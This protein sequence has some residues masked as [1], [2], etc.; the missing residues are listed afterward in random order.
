MVQV[1]ANEIVKNVFP[2]EADSPL[3]QYVLP[4]GVT[5]EGVG[6]QLLPAWA[7]QARNA[8]GGTQDY[9]NQYSVFLAQETARFRNGERKTAPTPRELSNRTRNWF[10]LGAAMKNASPVSITPTPAS[11]FYIERARAYR[12][13][14]FAD[15]KAYADQHSGNDW[16]AQYLADFPEYFEMSMTLTSNTT[17]IQATEQG[18]DALKKHADE[19]AKNP[20]YGWA[21]AGPENTGEFDA[22]VYTWMKTHGTS[23][24]SNK[25]FLEKLSPEEALAKVQ[26]ERGWI[27][28]TK[29]ARW[30]DTQMEAMGLRNL[31][32][33]GAADLAA[34]KSAFVTQLAKE[35]P[36]WYAEYTKR[37]SG[38]VDNFI[39]VMTKAWE[40]S[41]E[42]K[43]RPDMVALQDYI[44][45][46][47]WMRDRLAELGG[48]INSKENVNLL[49]SWTAYTA[50]LA[51]SNLAFE[52]MFNRV[53]EGDDLNREL[54]I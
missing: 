38:K 7:K 4:F 41:P 16:Q 42:L 40:K 14:Y 37:D 39:S 22:G 34:T 50:G 2:K 44:D 24:G 51:R 48:G 53:L 52:D 47:K 23:P 9:A 28:Y 3:L 54:M 15:P 30:I 19:I 13:E 1:P 49:A 43:K 27:E 26:A 32:Q 35:N 25:N 10:I 20:E 45:S 6:S 11:Q 33:K 18:Y 17:G 21:F 5:D 46:R 12:N 29:A 31:Q 8:F 36:Q